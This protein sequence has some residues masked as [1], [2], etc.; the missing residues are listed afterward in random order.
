MATTPYWVGVTPAGLTVRF[1]VWTT[2]RIVDH[3]TVPGRCFAGVANNDAPATELEGTAASYVTGAGGINE[4][5]QWQGGSQHMAELPLVDGRTLY[6]N[7]IQAGRTEEDPANASRSYLATT[8]GELD[9]AWHVDAS[10]DAVATIL[11]N[12]FIAP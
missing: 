8:E 2:C 12:S 1:G 10:P 9:P 4:A 5:L 7:A 11:E 6:V 3:P